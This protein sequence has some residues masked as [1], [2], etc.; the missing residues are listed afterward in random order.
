MREAVTGGVGEEAGWRSP[1]G[2]WQVMADVWRALHVEGF[3]WN[4]GSTE[5]SRRGDAG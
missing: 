2:D 3:T 4:T 1:C 5:R